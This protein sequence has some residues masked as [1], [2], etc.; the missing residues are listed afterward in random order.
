MAIAGSRKSRGITNHILVAIIVL[1]WT[2]PTLGL[3]VSSIRDK[4]QL[5]V[6]GW[7][8]A[9]TTTESNQTG[10]APPA[11]EQVEQDGRFILAGNL[12]EEGEAGTV[13]S[14]GT[15]V[16]NP[17]EFTAGETADIG[18]GVTLTV[19]RDGAFEFVSPVAFEGARGQRI[20]YRAALPPR[21]T[22]DNYREV[23]ASAGI[24]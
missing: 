4:D 13:V 18:G 10:R 5:S 23:L 15:R 11:S 24:G 2:V 7:W 12:F 9:L 8:T 3:F 19:N 17:N 16:Q 1:V 6:S 21:F 20:F 22:L 14:F